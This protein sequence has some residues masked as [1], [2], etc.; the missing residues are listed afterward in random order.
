LR[1]LANSIHLRPAI[2][3]VAALTNLNTP[4]VSTILDTFGF[5]S[6]TLALI[7]GTETDTNVTTVVLLEESND[8]GMA[9]ATAVADI[10][11]I[12]TE[13]LA[14]F[15]FDDDVECRK[16]GYTGSRRYIRATV[17]PSGNDA[18]NI[19]LAG[20]W[21]LGHPASYPTANPPQ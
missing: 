3:P 7:T 1:D 21:I 2:A 14:A 15:Q 11:L 16:L 4:I 17:T 20:A 19:F 13:V 12:G 8:S 18:G 5:G 9:G 10:D 6:A